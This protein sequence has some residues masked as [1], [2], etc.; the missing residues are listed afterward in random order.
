MSPLQIRLMV[1]YY[2]SVVD[3]VE[4]I[5]A[6]NELVK[7]GMLQ[8]VGSDVTSYKITDKGKAYVGKL[9]SIPIPTETTVYTFEAET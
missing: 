4:S 1:D 8:V 2:V 3:F 6:A 5:Q 9:C 7:L